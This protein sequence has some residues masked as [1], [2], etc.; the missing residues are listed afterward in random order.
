VRSANAR[1]AALLLEYG[2]FRTWLPVGLDRLALQALP[3][4]PGLA[5]VSAML[6]SD[7]GYAPLNPPEWIAKIQPQVMLLS[8]GAGDRDGRPDGP[9]LAATEGYTLLRT[10]QN[11]W[12]EL[13]KDGEQMWV[14][15]KSEPQLVSAPCLT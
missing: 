5:E 7:G 14:D 8:A 13:A 2:N 3:T 9:L 10:D 4:D 1:G 11:G 15:R 12:I 6:L